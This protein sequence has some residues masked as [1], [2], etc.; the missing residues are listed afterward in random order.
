MTDTFTGNCLCGAVAFEILGPVDA[1]HVCYCSRC[2]KAT[3]SAQACNLF[4]GA[5]GFRWLRGQERVRRFELPEAKRFARAFCDTCGS[6]VP[7][8]NRAG[9]VMLVPAG[10]LNDDPVVRP[11][12]RIFWKDRAPWS[13]AIA[14]APAFDGY[15]DGLGK[16]PVSG[17]EGA[18]NVPVQDTPARKPSES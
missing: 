18:G 9:T 15:P 8:L 5:D 11:Q 13:D 14:T 16:P 10:A 4:V 1:F 17:G 3:S 12:D 7:C 2:R 6:G